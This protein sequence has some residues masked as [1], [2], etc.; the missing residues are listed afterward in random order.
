MALNLFQGNIIV[1]SERDQT[2]VNH[3]QKQKESTKTVFIVVISIFRWLACLAMNPRA[4][5]RIPAWRAAHPAVYLS[6]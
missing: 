6:F 3:K 5:V 2:M 4:R 1:G